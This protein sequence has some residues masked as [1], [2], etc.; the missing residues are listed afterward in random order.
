MTS[1]SG[2]TSYASFSFIKVMKSFVS[3]IMNTKFYVIQLQ[4]YLDK[5]FEKE[6]CGENVSY[7]LMH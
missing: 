4:Q 3:D 2:K 5:I 6:K 1:S 7:S